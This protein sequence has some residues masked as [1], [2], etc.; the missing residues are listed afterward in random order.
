MH[1]HPLQTQFN[2]TPPEPPKHTW[3]V[4]LGLTDVVA[5]D[6]S[7]VGAGVVDVS[8]VVGV[9]VVEGTGS[10]VRFALFSAIALEMLAQAAALREVI[11]TTVVAVGPSTSV[12]RVTVGGPEIG[13]PEGSSVTTV[14]T[15]TVD[16]VGV[17]VTTLTDEEEK[18]DG[19]VVRLPRMPAMSEAMSAAS[20]AE[21]L[22]VVDEVELELDEVLVVVVVGLTLIVTT[23][24]IGSLPCGSTKWGE[25]LTA[26]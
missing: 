20:D 11:P 12:V 23:S 25:M 16:R 14:V 17:T 19:E 24:V 7:V 18:E 2:C 13:L 1:N 22:D 15:S 4:A 10:G 9:D 5:E 26:G 21:L 6:P 3:P 8:N